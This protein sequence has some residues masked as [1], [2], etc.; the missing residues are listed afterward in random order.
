MKR[1]ERLHKSLLGNKTLGLSYNRLILNERGRAEDILVEDMNDFFSNTFGLKDVSDNV[2]SLKALLRIDEKYYELILEKAFKVAYGRES[3]EI[4]EYLEETGKWYLIRG[5]PETN[6]YFY[7]FLEEIP[8]M[9]LDGEKI[10]KRQIDAQK[11]IDGMDIPVWYMYDCKT[12]GTANGTYLDYLNSTDSPIQN[13]TLY[14]YYTDD[15]AKLIE[16]KNKICV[17]SAETLVST[18]WHELKNGKRRFFSV[19]RIPEFNCYGKLEYIICMA[20][21]ITEK[22]FLENRLMYSEKKYRSLFETVNEG[23]ALHEL[24]FDEYGNPADYLI[25]DV[26]PKFEE[27]LRISKANVIGKKATE[28]YGVSQ[29]PYL[30]EYSSVALHGSTKTFTTYFPPMDKYFHISVFS[31]EKN[32]FATIF[33]DITDIKRLEKQREHMFGL[34]KSLKDINRMFARDKL[35]PVLLQ[36]ICDKI[37]E[38][39]DYIYS[40]ILI[41]DCENR[42]DKIYSSGQKNFFGNEDDILNLNCMRKILG[43]HETFFVFDTENCDCGV[44]GDEFSCILKKLEYNDKTMGILLSVAKKVFEGNKEEQMIFEEIGGEIS[45]FLYGEEIERKRVQ[46]E[47]NLREIERQKSTLIDNLPGCVY[48]CRNDELW[49]MDFLSDKVLELTGYAAEDFINNKSISF[50][51][52]IYEKD[53]QRVREDIQELVGLGESFEIS[54]RIVTKNG[55]IKWVWEKGC[56]VLGEDGNLRTLEGFISDINDLKITESKLNEELKI[57]NCIAE[58][59][60]MILIPNSS[61]VEIADKLCETIA[62][63]TDSQYS[64]ISIINPDDKNGLILSQNIDSRELIDGLQPGKFFE[65]LY[66][67]MINHGISEK[68][69]LVVNDMKGLAEISYDL[70][71]EEYNGR[72]K[73]MLCIPAISAGDTLG[74][75]LLM[76]SPKGYSENDKQKIEKFANLFAIALYKKQNE[77]ELIRAKEEAE[78]AN[79][80]KSEFLANMSHEIRTPMNGIIGMTDLMLTTEIDEE[81]REYLEAVKTSSFSLLDIINDILDFS[82]IEAGKLEIQESVF[83]IHELLEN[84]IMIMKV[85]AHEKNLEMLYEFDM[86]IPEYLIGDPLRIRQ[87]FLN[88]LSNS[89]KFTERGEIHISIKTVDFGRNLMVNGEKGVDV[90]QINGEDDILISFTVKDTGIGIPED[91]IDQ[92]FE[93]FT[94]ADSTTTRKFGGTGLGLA[95]SKKLTQMMNGVISVESKLDV[96][97]E[98]TFLL[99]LKK[100]GKYRTQIP[101]KIARMKRILVVDDNFTNRKI[102]TDMLKY[103]GIE[104]VTA[105]DGPEALSIVKKEDENGG[106]FDAMLIDYHMPGM[107]GIDL[108]KEMR[109]LLTGKENSIIVM[110]SSKDT[111]AQLEKI[112]KQDRMEHLIKPVTMNDLKKML[113]KF[114]ENE[115]NTKYTADSREGRNKV[116]LVEDDEVNLMIMNKFLNKNGFDAAVAKDG[117]QA[118]EMLEK[119]KYSLILMDV[120]MP[121][122]NGMQVTGRL[123]ESD[124]VNRSTPVIAVTADIGKVSREKCLES[125]MND[126]ISKPFDKDV[127]LEKIRKFTDGDS[128]TSS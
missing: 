69:D 18:E 12:Y 38:N 56:G 53:R 23:I 77:A 51:D 88:L 43:E 90:P 87:I 92:I 108:I 27:I 123:R 117:Y 71:S 39:E 76:N 61:I 2:K 8:S 125:G 62:E 121:G 15:T 96:G 31:P 40:A 10:L 45:Y 5:V 116:L 25:L 82:K 107:N 1:G 85:K 93:S 22:R 46:M 52:I 26:N 36:N 55:E 89:L 64:V 119:E 86:D 91:K 98:F 110:L 7:I 106:N 95:I 63:I 50:E 41:P 54:Y 4:Y 99:P 9:D 80:T 126:F 128:L 84:I 57:S 68:T 66:H 3:Q 30:D 11:L 120:H 60:R 67:T 113:L 94:Q 14:D 32:K 28:I 112:K 115:R 81:Q 114:V 124:S 34:L 59:S 19:K 17:D 102:L 29:A 35:N 48:R 127:L 21:D 65:K 97:S 109:T 100:A 73:N 49:T 122:M 37:C 111:S 78:K 105:S 70:Y 74:H 20:E 13:G 83:N 103:W 33:W 16:S 104:A 44:T 79:R 72:V 42:I 118:I 58:I 24:L 101:K 6:G 75:F 47:K